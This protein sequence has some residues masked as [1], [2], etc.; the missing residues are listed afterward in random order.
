MWDYC[1]TNGYGARFHNIFES[2]D[3]TRVLQY[4]NISIKHQYIKKNQGF[5]FEFFLRINTLILQMSGGKNEKTTEK[6]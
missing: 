6:L 2:S 3:N 1:T 5:R 4:K